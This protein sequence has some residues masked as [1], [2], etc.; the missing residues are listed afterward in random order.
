MKIWKREFYEKLLGIDKQVIAGQKQEQSVFE[1]QTEIQ[2]L[3]ALV[4]EL[5]G[6]CKHPSHTVMF[7]SWRPGAMQPSHVCNHCNGYIGPATE[8]EGKNL[9][10]DYHHSLGELSSIQYVGGG[11]D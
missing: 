9:W 6:K 1:L 8:E 2:R 5:Q 7:W 11:N 3:Q 4:A 10:K